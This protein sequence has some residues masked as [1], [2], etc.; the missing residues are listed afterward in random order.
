MTTYYS[1]QYLITIQI[2]QSSQTHTTLGKQQAGIFMF[3]SSLC[4]TIRCH[5][6]PQ[7]LLGILLS[8]SIIELWE[9]FYHVPL[10][11]ASGSVNNYS[12]PFFWLCHD[13]WVPFKKNKRLSSKQIKSALSLQ[14]TV[15]C[16]ESK[17]NYKMETKKSIVLILASFYCICSE[18]LD[19]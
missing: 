14:L 1:H 12:K 17:Q 2:F 9:C 10:E 4:S 3:D 5:Q 16:M 11:S 7:Q 18:K 19:F 6:A 8:D 15:L 13:F